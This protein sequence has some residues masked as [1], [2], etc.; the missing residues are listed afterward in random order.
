[1]HVEQQQDEQPQLV[2]GGGGV[3]VQQVRSQG[4]G[5]TDERELRAADAA[6]DYCDARIAA[7]K[8]EEGCRHSWHSKRARFQVGVFVSAHFFDVIDAMRGM[9]RLYLA[10]L[11]L[12]KSNWV[13]DVDENNGAEQVWVGPLGWFRTLR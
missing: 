10:C 12:N 5:E 2:I 8:L 11:R 4:E 9:G 13:L 6:L 1:M 7:F 3:G